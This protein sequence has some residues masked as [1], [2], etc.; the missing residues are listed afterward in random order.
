MRWC[1]ES[2][3]RES[4]SRTLFHPVAEATRNEYCKNFSGAAL[5]L[6]LLHAQSFLVEYYFHYGR[7]CRSGRRNR[8]RKLWCSWDN[9]NNIKISKLMPW[10]PLSPMKLKGLRHKPPPETRRR[11]WVRECLSCLLYIKF[12]I[13]QLSSIF[14]K[15]FLKHQNKSREKMLSSHTP[16]SVG[17]E[18]CETSL[19][20]RIVHVKS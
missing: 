6:N 2:S 4:F 15:R 16:H 18:G 17:C 10:H 5:L 12:L 13:E 11:V 20:L 19:G 1:L 7:R 9:K 8:L 14:H 3:H